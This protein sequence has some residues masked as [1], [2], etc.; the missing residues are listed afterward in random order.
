MQLFTLIFSQDIQKALS[1][2]LLGMVT[3]IPKFI[4]ATFILLVGMIVSKIV[5][6]VIVGTLQKAKV[7]KLGD[8]L[9]EIDILANNNIEIKLS[10]IAGKMV[11]YMMMLIFI[12][13]AVGVLDMPVL[14]ELIQDVIKFVPNLIAA[15][16][17]LIAG[18]LLADTLK[19]VVTTTCKS[20]GMPSANII[21]YFV[22]YFI[23]INVIIVALSQAQINTDFFA[24]NISIII[25]GAVLAFSIGYG[26]ASKD[27]V[28]SFLASY[29]TKDKLNIGDKVTLNGVTGTI[30][31]VDKSSVTLDTGQKDVI[32]PLNKILLDNIEIHH[33]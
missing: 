10:N 27:L 24:Q 23:F 11:Y 5:K 13:T 31:N 28:A 16:V 17:I 1:D 15:F 8:K 33:K 14:A 22:F 12:M 6:K 29:Y 3:A 21:G 32:I 26:L 18:I 20:I 19:N 4:T 2:M 30:S 9:N 7:D 25:G